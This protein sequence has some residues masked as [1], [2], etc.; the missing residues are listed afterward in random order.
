MKKIYF[1][2]SFLAFFVVLGTACSTSK[3]NDKQINSKSATQN[4]KKVTNDTTVKT[5]TSST[6]KVIGINLTGESLENGQV[7]L[8]WTVSDELKKI[9]EKYAL[10]WGKDA[11]PEYPGRYWF[12]RGPDHFEKVWSG[13]P[14]GNAHF[15][16]CVMQKEKCVKYSN[17][18]ELEVK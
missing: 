4:D 7:K 5:T 10:T 1:L 14:T 8:N 11:N 18:V 15:R 12:W 16:V 3:I 17:D 13:F 2:F 6:T 9:A